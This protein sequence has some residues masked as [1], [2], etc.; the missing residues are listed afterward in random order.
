MTDKVI[1]DSFDTWTVIR[2]IG[3]DEVDFE[4]LLTRPRILKALKDL[5]EKT[6]AQEIEIK[7]LSGHY[8]ALNECAI[9]EVRK[10]LAAAGVPECGFVD[11][12]A[13]LAAQ[14]IIEL[15]DKT[16]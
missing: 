14:M 3:G 16:R 8:D 4:L 13:A 10:H 6:W 2:E 12:M 1:K 5:L 11:D 7:R 9:M 15:R